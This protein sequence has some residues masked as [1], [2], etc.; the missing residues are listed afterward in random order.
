MKMLLLLLAIDAGTVEHISV[1]P[2]ESLTVTVTAAEST[3]TARPLTPVVLIPGLIGASF[4]FRKVTPVLAAAG[5]ATY[6]VEPLGTGT[7][8][9]PRNG[10]YSLDAQADRVAAVLDS[11]G[12]TGAVVVGTNFGASVAMRIAYRHP[13]RVVAVLSLDGGPVDRS[14]TSGTSV[15]M[16]LA[17]I[18]RFL[19]ARGIAR[20]RIHDA[21]RDYSG[22]TSWVTADVV[23]AY[24]RPI[25]ND[26]GGAAAVLSDMRNAAVPAP[27][28]DSLWRIRQPV[29][30]LIGAANRRGGI[31][32]SETT[33]LRERIPDFSVDS[34]AGSGVYL[35]EERPDVVVT[36]VLA[37]ADSTRNTATIG[38]GVALPR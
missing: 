18:L 29:R 8:S 9:H 28:A 17:P 19:G 13:E 5:H 10:D 25:V 30:L 38:D 34:I 14:S 37:L 2:R 33:L 36:A 35:H 3:H 21:L 24:A 27:L 22:D 31:Q 1:A 15:A 16:R 23:E 32:T 6:V 7:S 20:R 4:G 11:L 12:V 26:L